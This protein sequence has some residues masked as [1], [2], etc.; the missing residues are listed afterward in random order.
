ML[1]KVQYCTVGPWRIGLPVQ[2]I[3]TCARLYFAGV[4]SRLSWSALFW[5]ASAQ[6]SQR[7][8]RP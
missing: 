3:T 1:Y 4:Q 8:M 2:Y 7:C 5:Q 6:P